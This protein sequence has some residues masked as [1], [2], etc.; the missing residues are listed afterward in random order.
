MSERAHPEHNETLHQ[1]HHDVQGCLSVIS[2][3]TEMLKGLRADERRFA[4]VCES[5]EQERRIATE[6]INKFLATT[7][8]GCEAEASE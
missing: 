8:G 3:G 7:C 2:M 5:I 6:L 4:E 1:L